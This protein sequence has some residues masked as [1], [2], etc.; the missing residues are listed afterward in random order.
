ME[1]EGMKLGMES[2]TRWETHRL[3]IAK[4]IAHLMNVEP[5]PMTGLWN[6]VAWGVEA[7]PA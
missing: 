5:V 2:G 1:L 6:M 7:R 3:G 4:L